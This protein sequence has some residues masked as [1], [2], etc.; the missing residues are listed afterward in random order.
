MTYGTAKL[1]RDVAVNIGPPVLALISALLSGEKK[2]LDQDKMVEQ[3]V[4]KINARR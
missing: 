2:K 4:K 1:I 3:I